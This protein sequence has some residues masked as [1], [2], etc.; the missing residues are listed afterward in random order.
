MTNTKWQ[1]KLDPEV[2]LS[3]LVKMNLL[4][5]IKEANLYLKTIF[6]NYDPLAVATLAAE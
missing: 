3:I 1:T 4:N 5:T 6:P 2:D